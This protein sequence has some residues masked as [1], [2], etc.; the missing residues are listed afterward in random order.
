MGL[1]HGSDVECE[2]Q[3]GKADSKV[4]GLSVWMNGAARLGRT[5]R[6]EKVQLEGGRYK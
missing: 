2:N 4:C 6:E 1:A 3:R 5:L